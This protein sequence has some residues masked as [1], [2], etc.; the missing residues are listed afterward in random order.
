[1][2]FKQKTKSG[3][4]VKQGNT[5]KVLKRFSG[6]NAGRRADAKITQLHAENNPKASNRGKSAAK[7]HG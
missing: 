3:Y 7:K 6:K 5:G 2:A 1:M 4:V